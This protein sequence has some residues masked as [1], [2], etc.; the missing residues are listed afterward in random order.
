MDSAA[1]DIGVDKARLIQHGM[2]AAIPHEMFVRN[3]F[4]TLRMLMN[5]GL[6]KPVRFRLRIF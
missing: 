4:I 1:L 2:A 3:Q 5:S 6:I